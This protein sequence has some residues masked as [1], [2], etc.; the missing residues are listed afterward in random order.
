MVQFGMQ[1]QQVCQQCQG[2]GKQMQNRDKCKR[3]KGGCMVRRRQLAEVVVAAGA[4][5]N[6]RITLAGLAD[7]APDDEIGPIEPGDFIVT[8]VAKPEPP[9]ERHGDD[10]LLSLQV[11]LVT[12]L[13]GGIV[14]AP[15]P[16]GTHVSVQLELCV[17]HRSVVGVEGKGFVCAAPAD[18]APP[19]S[20]PL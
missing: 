8:L 18:G 6:A 10:L 15:L 1:L 7:E 4:R 3:C 17:Q 2:T 16:D 20:R 19:E 9:Y 12:A 14:R 11:P 13:R 5:D